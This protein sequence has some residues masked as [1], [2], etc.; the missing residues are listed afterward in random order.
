[1]RKDQGLY[2]AEKLRRYTLRFGKQC[3]GQQSTYLVI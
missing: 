1:M 2:L 3:A